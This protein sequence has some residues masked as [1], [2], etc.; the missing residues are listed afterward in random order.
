MTKDIQPFDFSVDLMKAI[1][2]QYNGAE[3]LQSLIGAK[4]AWYDENQ[5]KFWADWIANVFNLATANDF[6]CAVWA[7]IL[8]FP[9]FFN[10]PI[11]ASTKPTWG[12][13]E[14]FQNFDNGNF[15]DPEG[16]SSIFL[17]TEQRR[18]ALQLRYFQ[19]VTAGT[20]PEINRF[21][22]YLFGSKGAA[23]LLDHGDMTQ[24][25]VFTFALDANLLSVIELYDLL[26]RPAGVD[27]TILFADHVPFGFDTN[28]ENFDNGAFLL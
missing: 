14:F 6:G 9:L 2:W 25:Y 1:I 3:N 12:F 13:D 15:S 8:A 24:T 4:Q 16:I 27:S 10:P 26:P 20:V 17:T 28:N 11:D 5:K 22:K 21:L 18:I 23:Y 7:Q 19:L